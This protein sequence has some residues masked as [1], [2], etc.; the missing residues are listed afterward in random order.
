MYQI[1]V[2]KCCSANKPKE[3]WNSWLGTSTKSLAPTGFEESNKPTKN[4]ENES[5]APATGPTITM[6]NIVLRSGRM[7]LNYNIK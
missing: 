6:S 7:D 3:P 2:T 4:I 5:A 1:P